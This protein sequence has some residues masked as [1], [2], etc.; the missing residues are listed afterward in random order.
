MLDE[1]AVLAERGDAVI[2]ITFSG[3]VQYLRHEV[4]GDGLVEIY[5]RPLTAEATV[6]TETRHVRRTPTFP[7]VEVI[8][9]LQPRTPTRKLTV[10]LTD[11]LKLR[12]RPTGQR[13][14]DLVVAGAAA[15]V[16]RA[17]ALAPPA[18]IVAAPP[19]PVPVPVPAPVPA[20]PPPKP[21]APA[22][23]VVRLATF[24]S[25]EE[26]R[27]AAPVPGAFAQYDVMVSEAKRA[28][29]TEYDLLLGY[30][31]TADAAIRARSQLLRRF[32]RA[33][34]V[35]LGVPPPGPAIAAVPTPK[36]PPAPPPA[37]AA[38]EVEARAAALMGEARQAIETGNP[39]AAVERLNALLLL[40]PNRQSR[41]AQELVGV[42]RER[43][44]ELDKARAEYELYLKL[45]PQ[46]E[47]A[48]RV[49]SR[50]AALAGAPAVAAAPRPARAPMD[51]LTGTISQY[52]YNGRTKVES[53]FN[54]PTTVDS[55]TF[56]AN[57]LSALVT[58]IDLS[59]RMRSESSDTRLVLRDTD[60]H[61]FLDTQKSYNRLTAAYYDYRGLKNPFS[62]RLGRQTGLSGGLPQR[63]DGALAGVGVAPK[64]RLTAAAGVPVEYPD[65][66]TEREF[67][68]T[69]LEF[70]NLG[71]HWSGNLYAVEQHA[72]GV[73]DR[74]AAGTELRY[75]GARAS[76][77]SLLD[78]D[79]SY[80]EWNVAM[81]Q[82]TWQSEGGTTINLLYDKRKAP[83]LTTTNAI[84]GQGTTSLAAL[85]QTTSEAQL[86]QL[87]RDV[88][89]TATQ[90]YAGFTTPL[91]KK[92]QL[93]GGV[94]LT[95]VDA[96]PSVVI[97]G[98][99]MPAQ[100]A[101]G[102]VYSYDAQLIGTNLYSRRDTTV[103]SLTVLDAPMQT[104]Y[105]LAVNNL[106]QAGAWTIEP[107]IRYYTQTD[108]FDVELERW[109]PVL[110]L[111]YQVH[112]RVALETELSWERTV[113]TGPASRD[114]ATRGF[115]YLG[116]RWNL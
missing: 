40:P 60:S 5:F 22:R 106:S 88:T 48:A 4:F 34:V 7:G 107:S 101:T 11:P 63:F 83:T 97:N 86:R 61:S 44:G 114:V 76:L 33:E 19:A 94:R 58:N 113:T 102:D 27:G 65:I 15:R 82:G 8:Y 24:R 72:D 32:P 79:T 57:D 18:P 69:S 6:A 112:E 20:P 80:Q 110:R 93:G 108:N 9:P 25:V 56:T 87:A 78:Y 103:T 116:Y 38:P 96:L 52:Y 85:L 54:T 75:F 89:A 115:F 14:I 51:Q 47:G 31:P 90:A 50:L 64:W 74:R 37:V 41:D 104:G 98:I 66:D 105:Q 77:F 30:F 39:G 71:E 10:R 12:V 3:P 73:L 68:G 35:D 16:A 55:A 67:W 46:G 42:A 29:R 91:D 62:L 59:Y 81:V 13:T 49:R 23:Y 84:F 2:R 43:A 21:E 70:E 111:T 45:Y 1:L 36:P 92:W 53:V 100:P 109:L 17:P 95:N 28:G 26:M 99:V